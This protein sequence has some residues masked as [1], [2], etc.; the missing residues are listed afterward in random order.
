MKL[1][2]AEKP[3]VATTIAKVL[4]ASTKKDGYFEG[5]DYIISYCVGHLVG[6][7]NPDIYDEKYANWNI[8]DLPIIPDEF[9]YK[10]LTGKE[11][12]YD[13]L[14][15]L[16]SRKDVEYVVNGCDAGRE[17]ELIFRLVYDKTNCSK[18]IKR[19]WV[20]SMEDSAIKTAFENLLDE[21]EVHNL[22]KS[23][24]CRAKADWLVGINF[25]RLFSSLYN[26]KLN[27]G[28]V[29]SPTLSMIVE[30]D[31]EISNFKPKDFYNIN[32]E[33]Q[34]LSFTSEKFENLEEA[35]SVLKGS[36]S[37]ELVID[38]V[39]TKKKTEKTPLLY[40]LTTLQRE[41]NKKLGYTS[42][43]TLNHLQAL[44]EKK[45]VTYPRTDSKYI[46]DDM[47]EGLGE[48]LE[49]SFN[50]LEYDANSKFVDI[51]S[52]NIANNKKV[53]D[54]TA[55][56]I[57]KN[58]KNYDKS[59]LNQ[60]ELSILELVSNR[61]ICA[62]SQA[63]TYNQTTITAT[64]NDQSFTCKFNNTLEQ[65]FKKY[66]NNKEVNLKK[67]DVPDTINI[68]ENDIIKDFTQ[69]LKTGTT[70]PKPLFTED[71]L[72]SYMEN[73]SKKDTDKSK[74]E[75]CGI[76]T[77]AT[78][79]SIIEKL[80]STGLVDRTGAGKTKNLVPS[81]K[82]TTLISILPENIKSSI[83]TVEWEEKL[84]LVEIGELQE[85]DFLDEI[86][87]FVNTTTKTYEKIKTDYKTFNSE[88]TSVGKCIKC[89]GDMVETQKTYSCY[90]KCGF[91]LLK[92]D[93]FFTAKKKS[94]TENIAK[95][96]LKG[97]KVK[98]MGCYSATTNKRY[99]AYVMID[100]EKTKDSKY[101]QYKI[102]FIK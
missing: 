56:L 42:A 10:V 70:T 11:K 38:K 44:Y 84:H 72:L 64:C 95:K 33:Y 21:E 26:Q 91:F 57:T 81:H 50:Y 89:G 63:Y 8:N 71:T 36:E 45:L 79:S 78:R 73:A 66:L 55:I 24:L 69:V 32:I 28:R 25:T 22:Y 27:V 92:E 14:D 43:D 29:V 17:G 35:E 82:G 37:Q 12:Q 23:A 61:I 74:K 80:I 4:G 3:S 75:F 93:R 96:L 98:L 9:L 34:N 99:D 13:I 31:T 62:L 77:P 19:L 47:V 100:Q 85:H 48:L 7:V 39:Q 90:D 20:S 51:N 54:H 30:R 53:T 5:N 88:A 46:T 6:L 94:I 2:I 15:E 65:G 41:A 16:L 86:I 60:E 68:K 49:D 59:K 58:L 40:D 76:G 102:E 97:E 67:E 87:E 18:P 1:V 52:N 101:T 83:L